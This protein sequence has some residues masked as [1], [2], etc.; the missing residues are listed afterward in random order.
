MFWANVVITRVLGPDGELRGF[1]KVNAGF[2]DRRQAEETRRALLEQREARLQAEEERRQAE[3]SYRASEETNRA[4]DEFL[5]TLSHELRTPMTAIVGWSRL[6][7][8]MDSSDPTFDEAIK[9]I[10]RS[11]QHQAQLLEDVLDVSRVNSGKL[12]LSV[13]RVEVLA[14]CQAALTTVRPAADGKGIR[15][16]TDLSPSLGE[17]FVDPTRL[18]QMVWNLLANAVKFTPGG[19]T[20]TLKAWRESSQLYIQVRDTGEGSLR[21]SR[22]TCSEPF[23]QH[24]GS[25]T[26]VHG[27]L[28]WDF[29]SCRY[30]A[31]R[32]AERSAPRV[33]DGKG[34]TFTLSLPGALGS[35]RDPGASRQGFRGQ[36]RRCQSFRAERIAH[37]AGR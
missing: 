14:I 30:L 7:P 15:I 16:E 24:E 18:Q 32:T 29:R 3:A 9:A 31:E 23:S 35:D 2:T 28:G 11:A 20:I 10:N 5:M 37:S 6:L 21:F 1:A 22:R 27:G 12:R 25:T 26:R 33:R 34:S 4:K 17:I 19:G 8:M 13:S 36:Y